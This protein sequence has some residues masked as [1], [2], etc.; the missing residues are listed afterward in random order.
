MSKSLNTSLLTTLII[1]L[2]LYL[3]ACGKDE[4]PKPTA[5]KSAPAQVIQPAAKPEI[6]EP[7]TSQPATA[8][9]TKQPESSEA[10]ATEVNP[11][12]ESA[13][14]SKPAPVAQQA[15]ANHSE[16]LN[17][18]RKSG[19]LVCHSVDKKLVGP[20]WK[21]VAAR[22]KAKADAR[23]LLIEKVS[24]GGRGSWTGVVG[25]VAMPPY[26]PRVSKENIKRLVD[27]VLSLQ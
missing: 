4:K 21:D 10:T 25:N 18:A 24:K 14:D 1:V 5:G 3:A 20:A 8:T 6:Q 15:D 19:C 7:E 12:P 26:Y 27:F 16:V 22:Y 9:E 17:L 13:P 2:T 11:M 23:S